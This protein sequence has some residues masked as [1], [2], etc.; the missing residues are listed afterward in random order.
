VLR[1]EELDGA[2]ARLRGYAFCPETMREMGARLGLR[3][4]TG[5][6]ATRPPR[7]AGRTR[8]GP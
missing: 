2:I 4:R 5:S 7:R 8:S 3:V 6:T 1:I